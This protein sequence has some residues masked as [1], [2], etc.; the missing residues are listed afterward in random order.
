[1]IM[2]PAGPRIYIVLCNPPVLVPPTLICGLWAVGW[3]D[4]SQ[5]NAISIRV[6]VNKYKL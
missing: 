1:M 2:S 3:G 4:K 5:C 6:R